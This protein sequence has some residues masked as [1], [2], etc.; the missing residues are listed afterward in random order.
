MWKLFPFEVAPEKLERETVGLAFVD[1]KAQRSVQARSYWKIKHKSS[2]LSDRQRSSHSTRPLLA[3]LTSSYPLYT[4]ANTA[5]ASLCVAH[6]EGLIKEVQRGKRKEKLKP[7]KHS[8]TLT[9]A[10]ASQRDERSRNSRRARATEAPCHP[11]G[12]LAG[13]SSSLLVVGGFTSQALT[14]LSSKSAKATKPTN[15]FAFTNIVQPA[16]WW[17]LW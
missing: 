8:I 9:F 16:R 2:H 7:H 4:H 5:L 13:K 10:W 6:Q 12:D 17:S 3:S 1:T 14:A 15:I 11:R